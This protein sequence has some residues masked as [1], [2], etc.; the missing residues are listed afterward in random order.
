MDIGTGSEIILGGVFG[1]TL[2][3]NIK[4]ISLV[5]LVLMILINVFLDIQI[6][7]ISG[8]NGGDVEGFVTGTLHANAE[9]VH[10]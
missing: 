1:G 7:I 10:I 3:K 6:H 5:P 4:V 8:I 9:G 2:L